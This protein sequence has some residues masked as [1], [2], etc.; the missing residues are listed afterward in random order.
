MCPKLSCCYGTYVVV[1]LE[2]VLYSIRNAHRKVALLCIMQ[3]TVILC[4]SW[5]Y[6]KGMDNVITL[7]LYILIGMYV[8]EY[9]AECD[10]PMCM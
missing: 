7:T 2:T 6:L 9:H 1:T 4:N 5:N 10:V 8:T 3:S